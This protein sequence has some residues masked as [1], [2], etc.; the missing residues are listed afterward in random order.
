MTW[1]VL[2][3][4]HLLSVRMF[5]SYKGMKRTN[6]FF[7]SLY[8]NTHTTTALLLY[9]PPS[10]SLKSNQRV[11]VCERSRVVQMIM[12]ICGSHSPVCGNNMIPHSPGI[13]QM[14]MSHYQGGN[15]VL[16]SSS[17]VRTQCFTLPSF[18][19]FP[20]VGLVVV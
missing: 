13:I 9:L 10:G 17:E 1:I 12:N 8:L 16:F 18:H 4:L 20:S 5:L 6:G 19:S 15:F 14:A 7:V 11:S 2:R 3:L